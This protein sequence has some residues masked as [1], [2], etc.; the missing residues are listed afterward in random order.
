MWRAI[1]LLLPVLLPAW[2][3]FQSVG[4]S[5]RI[6]IERDGEWFEARPPP[7]RLSVQAMLWR[8]VWNAGWNESLFLT[9]CAERVLE[10]GRPHARRE[11][12]V[13]TGSARFRVI[14]V[15]RHGEQL[16]REIRFCSDDL[17]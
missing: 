17:A 15:E 11:I 8:L 4:P 16:S 12:M 14:E 10:D 2:R 5:P 6:E 3:F 7:S 1:S 9:S 13:R